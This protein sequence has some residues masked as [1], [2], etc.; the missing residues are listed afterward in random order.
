MTTKQRIAN[1]E[2]EHDINHKVNRYKYICVIDE[3]STRVLS[4]TEGFTAQCCTRENG[5]TDGDPIHF[6]ARADLDNFAARP[7]IDLTLIRLVDE[8]T[9]DIQP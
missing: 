3:T 2:Q 5:G 7:D 6:V 4:Q 9:K 1:L 8:V